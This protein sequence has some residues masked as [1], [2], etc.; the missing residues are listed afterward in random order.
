M[1]LGFMC[2]YK[3]FIFVLI[4]IYNIQN[5]MFTISKIHYFPQDI[6]YVFD[7]NSYWVLNNHYEVIGTDKSTYRATQTN[8]DK[9]WPHIH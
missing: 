3:Y 8:P 5:N 4:Y 2:A 6:Q 1:I 7:N 9:L